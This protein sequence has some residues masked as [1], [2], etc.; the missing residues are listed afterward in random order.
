MISDDIKGTTGLKLCSD[1]ARALDVGIVVGLVNGWGGSGVEGRR[2]GRPDSARVAS[3]RCT[4]AAGI[5]NAKGTN[6]QMTEK[7][8]SKHALKV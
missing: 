2:D 8:F 6:M 3:R 5:W 7:S 1:N 4:A